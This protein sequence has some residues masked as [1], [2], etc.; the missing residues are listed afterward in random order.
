LID[1]TLCFQ[2]FKLKFDKLLSNVAFI[3]NLRHYIVAVA[4][5]PDPVL[6]ADVKAWNYR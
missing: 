1:P 5:L 4:D 6:D 3:F 2:L